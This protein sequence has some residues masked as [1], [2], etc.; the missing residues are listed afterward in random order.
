MET[1][2]LA[3]IASPTI[4]ATD[5]ATGSASTALHSMP[6]DA[7]PSVYAA[8]DAAAKDGHLRY[9]RLV[10]A[11]LVLLILAA[12]GSVYQLPAID[13]VRWQY[14]VQAMLL[15][16]AFIAKLANRLR[17]Y[18]DQWFESRAIAETVKSSTWRYMT[19]IEPFDGDDEVADAAFTTALQTTLQTRGAFHHHLYRA[20]P[21]G[22]PITH[23]MRRQRALPFPERK[24]FYQQERLADQIR[25]YSAKADANDRYAARWFWASLGFEG[26]ALVGAIASIATTTSAGVVGLFATLSAGAT[27]WTQLGRHNELRKSY[28]LAAYELTFLRIAMDDA[29]EEATFAPTALEA[30]AAISREHTMWMAKRA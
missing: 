18:D 6:E 2:P 22:E 8:A 24:A 16:G 12:A 21:D 10:Q 23:F 1:Q 30:E 19:R 15:I 28:G 25:W 9:V 17:G 20:L 3:D 29:D 26:L 4:V 7:Y 11:E 13:E 14:A 27:A 5:G